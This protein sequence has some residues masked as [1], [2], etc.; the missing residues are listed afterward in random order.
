[1]PLTTILGMTR[2]QPDA[3]R[4]SM[5]GADGHY[6][7]VDLEDT[8]MPE[9]FLAYQFRGQTMPVLQGFPLRAVLRGQ[10]GAPWVKWLVEIVVE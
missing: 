3:A 5:S 8:L 1:M 6:G 10:I 2:V 9:Y 4:I 7:F